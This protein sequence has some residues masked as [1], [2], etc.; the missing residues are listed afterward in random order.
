MDS[1]HDLT[2]ATGGRILPASRIRDSRT[3][4]L[5]QIVTDSRQ[6][7]SGDV[8]WALQGSESSRRYCFLN[9]AFL[10]WARFR[11]DCL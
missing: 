8:F 11:R 9:E 2:Q 4:A 10:Q 5:G 6:M 7:R 1:L 3:V